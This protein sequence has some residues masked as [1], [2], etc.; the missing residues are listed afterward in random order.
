MLSCLGWFVTHSVEL[1]GPGAGTE[2]DSKQGERDGSCTDCANNLHTFIHEV[3]VYYVF[4]VY[5]VHVDGFVRR[6][7]QF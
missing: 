5:H 7:E 4:C 6:R 1:R 2:R 3:Y